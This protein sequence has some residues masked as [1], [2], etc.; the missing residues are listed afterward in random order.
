MEKK[1]RFVGN[2]ILIIA[3]ILTIAYNDH[4]LFVDSSNYYVSGLAYAFKYIPIMLVAAFCGSVPSMVCVLVLFFYRC[5]IYSSFSYLTFIYLMVSIIINELTKKRMFNRIGKTFIVSFI[6]QFT[7]GP[8][9]GVLLWLLSGRGISTLTVTHFAMYYMNETLGTWTGCLIIYCVFRFLPV[10]KKLLLEN[11]KY[12]V[13]PRILDD[14]DRYEAEGRSRL[15]RVVMRVIVFEAIILGVSAEIASN[16]LVPTMK[17]VSE[18]EEYEES[19]EESWEEIYSTELLESKVS[20]SLE[21]E[22]K[23]YAQSVEDQYVLST[24]L[25]DAQFSV[26]LAMLISIIVIPLSIFVNQYA[27]R[28]IAIPIKNLSKAVTDIYNSEELEISRKVSE[29]HNL[30]IHTKD[31]IE[32]L[33]HAVDLTFYRLMEYI[34]LVKTRQT[35]ED[36]L[37]SEKTA[38]EAKS[39]FLS[40]ISHEIRTPI[41]AVLGFDEMILRETEDETI[42]GYARDIQGSGRTLLALINDILDFSKIEAGKMEIIPVEYE[43][44]S[45]I[46]DLV[47]MATVKANEKKLD[48]NVSINK[49]LPHALYGDE[50]RVKQCILN[51][52]NNAIKYTESGSVNLE[53]DFEKIEKDSI[54]LGNLYEDD[55]IFLKIKV[56]DTGIGIKEEDMDKLSAAFERIDEKRNRTIEGT[57][58]GINIVNSLLGMMGSKLNV[59]SEYGKGSVFYFDIEQKVIDNEPIGNLADNYKQSIKDAKSYV[60]SFHAPSGRILVVD[61]TK[62]N[63]TVIKGLLKQTQLQV[64]T[65]TGGMEAIEMVKENVYDMIF[66]DHRMPEMDGIQTF[67]AMQETEGNLNIDKPVIALTANAISGSREMYYKEGFT[68]Y[69]SKPV[70]PAKLE[71]MI[72]MYLPPEKVSRPGDSDFVSNAEEDN[73]LERA[74]MQELLKVSGVDIEYAIERCGSPVAARDVMKDF[75]MSIDERSGLIEKYEREDDIANYTIY[76]HGL[77]SSA[78]A[79]GAIELSEKAEYLEKCGNEKN[80]EEIRELTPQLL[81]LYRSYLTKLEL[82]EDDEDENKPEI[83]VTELEGAYASIKEFV[84]ASYFDSADDILKMLEDYRIPDECK[85]KHNEVKRLMSAVDRDALLNI[86]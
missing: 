9:W 70:D 13:D 20:N 82:F 64:D 15:S 4:V 39:R 53:I 50:I 10:E 84:S 2:I 37:Q 68:N 55:S 71:E 33:Y 63:L 62:T 7:T 27:Q 51:I 5:I 43:L 59:K 35:I 58:L 8:F 57:G 46:N 76:V 6:I 28:R 42:L 31:E 75:R 12:Y 32:E 29:V 34:E 77:K 67:H 86:L 45:L 16:T 1:K 3:T 44:G 14:D 11:G 38:N 61:D 56:I 54:E 23:L 21:T 41:N 25:R 26:K 18:S 72:L 83:G 80:I 19:I 22:A 48:F 47:S 30:D 79:I 17:Y 69:M 85:K 52:V 40:N 74:A 24:G 60:E 65:A 73:E 78:K 36:Q 49:D 81:E 66:L